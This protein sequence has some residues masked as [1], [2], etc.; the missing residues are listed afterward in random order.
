[1]GGSRRRWKVG[2]DV[3]GQDGCDPVAE[4]RFCRRPASYDG[5]LGSLKGTRGLGVPIAHHEE[6]LEVGE[7][8]F[9]GLEAGNLRVPGRKS[10]LEG[11]GFGFTG[12]GLAL[13]P[14]LGPRGSARSWSQPPR[15]FGEAPRSPLGDAG[16][17]APCR[18]AAFYDTP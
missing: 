14:W 9:V 18:R 3:H 11:L 12:L 6:V 10:G 4:R 2:A 16:G 15:A 8:A 1:M 17:P 7:A 5:G 13:G